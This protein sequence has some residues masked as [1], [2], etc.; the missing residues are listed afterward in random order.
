MNLFYKL[1]ILL[2]N[3]IMKKSSCIEIYDCFQNSPIFH[4]SPRENS[5]EI[6]EL[7]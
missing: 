5:N 1:P 4:S 2:G 6:K 7:K 3:E